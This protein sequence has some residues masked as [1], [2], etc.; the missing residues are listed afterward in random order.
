MYD[1]QSKG[2]SYTAGFFMLL[3]FAVAGAILAQVIYGP[4]WTAM[5]GKDLKALS[6]GMIEPQDTNAVRLVQCISA[7]VGFLV[8][9]IVTASMLHRRPFQLLGFTSK[10]RL[11]QAGMVIGIMLIALFVST[12][13]SYLNHQIPIPATWKTFFEKLETDYNRM[14]EA[15]VRLNNATDFIIALFVMA[16]LPALCEEAL[17]RGGLQNFLAR[18]TRLPWLAIIIVSLIF[19]LVH[20][21]YYGFLSRLFLG[22]V[23]GLIYQYSGKLWLTI[24]AHFF[25]NALALTLLFIYKSMGK[26]LPEAI[27]ETSGSWWGILLFPVLI[28]VFSQFR[29]MTAEPRGIMN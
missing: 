21:S 24:L 14:V 7:I 4:I 10:T 20:L 22:I 28:V 1:D 9:A 27:N 2:I 6:D 16:F 15:I 19:S 12:A 26:S 18:S 3:A 13:L 29:R 5:T 11:G 25:N 23:L 8:P 17:F